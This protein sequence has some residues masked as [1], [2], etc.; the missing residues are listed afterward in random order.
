M[1]LSNGTA[2]QK[3]VFS[4]AAYILDILNKYSNLWNQNNKIGLLFCDATKIKQYVFEPAKLSSIL[5]AYRCWCW[6]LSNN[7]QQ[8]GIIKDRK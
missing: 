3:N 2:L 4:I 7:I 5:G 6:C 1:D 8:L